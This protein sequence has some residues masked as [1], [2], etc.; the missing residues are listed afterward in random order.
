MLT[1][2]TTLAHLKVKIFWNKNYDVIIY[3]ND[4]IEKIFSRESN[5]IVDLLMWPK[6][7]NSSI[8]MREV[9]I[10]SLDKDLTRKNTFLRSSLGSGS[11]ISDWH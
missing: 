3:V 4:F 10:T 7:G 8:C 9:I 6:F 2:M 5:Y 1:K 11:I